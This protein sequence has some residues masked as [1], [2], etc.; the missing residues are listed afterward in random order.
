MGLGRSKLARRS[1]K[2]SSGQNGTIATESDLHSNHEFNSCCC[3]KAQK[4]GANN[5]SKLHGPDAYKPKLAPKED[6]PKETQ[7][8]N[9]SDKKH[10]P[11]IGSAVLMNN[12][13]N[14][15]TKKE[16][17]KTTESTGS[18]GIV[19]YSEDSLANEDKTDY[20]LS[21][22][23]QEVLRQI[24]H[25]FPFPSPRNSP[26][27]PHKKSIVRTISNDP[28]ILEH[29]CESPNPSLGKHDSHSST[30]PFSVSMTSSTAWQIRKKQLN[31]LFH[32][33]HEAPEAK[34]SASSATLFS[35]CKEEKRSAL[36]KLCKISVDTMAITA[37]PLDCWLKERLKNWVQLSGH[38]GTIV[39]ASNHTIYKK[40]PA[41]NNIEALAYEQI[42]RDQSLRGLTPKFFH[43]RT[44]NNSS[45]IEIQ[46]L[47][48]QFPNTAERA[49]M[50]IKI[51]CRTFLES[52]VSNTT[53]RKD[54]YKKMVEI[55]PDEPT[56]AER[57]IEA[58][59]KLRYMQFRESKSSTATLGFR[60]EAAQLPG[61]KL[62]KSFQKVRTRDQVLETL[63]QFFGPRAPQ[64]KKQLAA[65]LYEMRLG[66]ERSEFFNTHEVVGSSIFIVFDDVRTNAW[67]IDFAKSVRVPEDVTLTHR[68]P[69]ELGNHEDGFLFGLDNL[70][71]ILER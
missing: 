28:A 30:P 9:R 52:E 59:T 25:C 43:E 70:I 7:E 39:P 10:D 41:G 11:S 24:I 46:D 35:D 36:G 15:S 51:G 8:D 60:I 20:N 31:N 26:R 16:R 53:K 63:T 17:L 38:E 50:D 27:P 21:Q 2:P 47:L 19:S 49:V 69:W 40:Q 54:L 12:W 58:I 5:N 55:D 29:R 23:S 48:S 66:V 14:E 44:H 65:R 45:F 61:G 71:E 42:M 62:Q 13:K 33:S 64:I 22:Q 57:S 1:A 6:C 34:T 67:I 37:L 56:E 32:R 68:K 18:A 4:P 3:L